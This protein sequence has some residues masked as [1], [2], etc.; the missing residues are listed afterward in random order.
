MEA[1]PAIPTEGLTTEDVGELTE[2]TREKMMEC[3]TRISQEVKGPP[4]SNKMDFDL[5]QSVE[6]ASLNDRLDTGGLCV[7][8]TSEKSFSPLFSL[9]VWL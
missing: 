2:R 7:A 3:F 8:C 6:N 4:S 1:L 9:H 5:I